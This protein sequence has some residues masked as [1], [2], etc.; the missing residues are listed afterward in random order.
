MR[1]TEFRY[2]SMIYSCV[3]V[4]H[5]RVEWKVVWSRAPREKPWLA[6]QQDNERVGGGKKGKGHGLGQKE[7]KLKFA[8][9]W[10]VLSILQLVDKML[11]LRSR[12]LLSQVWM[13]IL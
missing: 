6:G 9:N 3:V 10:H 11:A 4:L 8:G 13:Q 1:P 12:A 7:A 2:K 5:G